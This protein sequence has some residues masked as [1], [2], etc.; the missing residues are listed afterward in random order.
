[1]TLDDFVK[2]HRNKG[3]R[4]GFA[5]WL[6]AR[7]EIKRQVDVHVLQGTPPRMIFN[8]L[9]TV[10]DFAIKCD[11]TVRKYAYALREAAGHGR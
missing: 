11:W 2:D 4:P 5:S 8:W 3:G 1:M 10:P 7:P 6:L 9:K